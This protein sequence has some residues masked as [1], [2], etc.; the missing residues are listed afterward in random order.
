M[1]MRNL[2][3]MMAAFAG[4]FALSET[5]PSHS[6]SDPLSQRQRGDLERKRHEFDLKRKQKQGVSSFTIDGITVYAR[7]FDNAIRKVIN[8]K[9]K[10]GK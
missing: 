6:S 10:N 9:R 7:D 3:H 8:Q 1:N 5:R 4:A 2:T